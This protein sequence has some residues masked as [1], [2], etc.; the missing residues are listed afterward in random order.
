MIKVKKKIILIIVALLLIISIG[1]IVLVKETAD[2]HIIDLAYDNS[3]KVPD[4]FYTELNEV[5]SVN[6]YEDG[7]NNFYCAKNLSEAKSTI[8]HYVERF[9]KPEDTSLQMQSSSQDAT[10][11]DKFYDFTVTRIYSTTTW[12]GNT[13]EDRR[14]SIERIFKCEYVSDLKYGRYNKV[15]FE[16]DQIALSAQ[17]D[18]AG[19]FA[20]RPITRESAEELVGVLWSMR[21]ANIVGMKVVSSSTLENSNTIKI[22]LVEMSVNG[23]DWGLNDTIFLYNSEYTID[24]QTGKITYAEDEPHK[25]IRASS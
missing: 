2:A 7:P 15:A 3:Y 6:Y 21:N 8:N 12:Q 22:T 5:G 16:K 18:Y 4:D 25:E 24:K 1:V 10:E 19:I 20:K 17:G 13:K 11:T 23:G 14:D 9:N